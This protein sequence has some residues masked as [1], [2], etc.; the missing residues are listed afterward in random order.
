M[1]IVITGAS[2][3]IGYQTALHLAGEG[4]SVIALSRSRI[5]L[6]KLQVE[7]GSD[8]LRLLPV[9]LADD[10][11]AEEAA[12]RI[13]QW[14]D[15]VDVVIHHAGLLVSKPYTELRTSDWRK[16]YEVN[17]FSVFN[18]NRLLYPL[19][20]K[21]R[22][23]GDVKAHV[24]HITSMGGVQGSVKFAGLSAYSSSKGA[25]ITMTECLAEEWKE[26]GVRVNAI[27]L[28]SVNTEMFA[29]AFPG[30]KAGAGPREVGRWIGEFA[31][32]GFGLFNGK[33][34]QMSASTP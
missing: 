14:F 21:G 29:E 8:A 19:L 26:E 4:H 24:V 3:G 11:D 1:N 9:D 5:G 10:A 28:G 30:M 31:T 17:V 2:K 33:V 13:A 15:R 20:Q 27:A 22:V 16:V 18:L 12:H 7:S 23:G 34:L 25:L 32:A 6:E